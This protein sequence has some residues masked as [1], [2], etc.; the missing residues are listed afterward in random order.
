LRSQ[1]APTRSQTVYQNPSPFLRSPIGNGIL[2]TAYNRQ[3]VFA[4]S[5]SRSCSSGT[6]RGY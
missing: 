4:P 5:R 6:C 1:V 2:P 3:A